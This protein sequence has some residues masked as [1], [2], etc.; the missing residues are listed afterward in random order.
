MEVIF[1][2]MVEEACK[3][4]KY[5]IITKGEAKAHLMEMLILWL[6]EERQSNQRRQRHRKEG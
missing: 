6:L 4:I 5:G 3:S 1:T 2:E